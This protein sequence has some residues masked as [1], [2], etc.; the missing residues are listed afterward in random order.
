MSK[1]VF[2]MVLGGLL[3]IFDGL[4]AL[5][6]APETRPE[7]VGIVIGSTFKGILAGLLIGLF[8]RK[9]RS[10]PLGIAFGLAIGLLFAYFVAAMQGKYYFEIMLPGGIL[11][12]IVGYATYVYGDAARPAAA[13]VSGM[14]GLI[15]AGFLAGGGVDGKA[16]LERLK[17]LAGT[18]RGHVVTEDGPPATVVYSVTAAGTAVTE[19]LFPGTSHEMLTVYHLEGDD[20]VLTH[21]CAMGNQPR[22]KLARAAGTD[23]VGAA[24]RLR[25]RDEHGS[26]AGRAHA[27]RPDDAA[28]CGSPR[29]RVG[30]V[31]EGQA[32]GSEPLLPGSRQGG[33]PAALIALSCDRRGAAWHGWPGCWWRQWPIAPGD[34]RKSEGAAD[35]SIEVVVRGTLRTGMMAIGGETTGTTVTARGATWE[36]DLRGDPKWAAQAESLSGKRVVV[37]GTLEVRPGVERR[38]RWIVTVKSLGPAGP[39]RTSP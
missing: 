13:S 29:G 8:A 39:S 11:G 5:I 4:T 32:D 12:L 27:L 31:R 24:L 26:R 14:V 15:L 18:W 30:G 9:V 25:G 34:G 10:L 19:A 6:S 38:Q 1:P 17:T 20:L 2:G 36:L 37:T 3:G 23:P 35:E 33:G 21:Y 16:A 28:G 7:I 22:M